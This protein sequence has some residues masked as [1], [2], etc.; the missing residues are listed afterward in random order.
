MRNNRCKSSSPLNGIPRVGQPV[1]TAKGRRPEAAAVR[2]HPPCKGKLPATPPAEEQQPQD[3]QQSCARCRAPAR[4]QRPELPPLH[5]P[6][7]APT[8][9]ARPFSEHGGV[10]QRSQ[11]SST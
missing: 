11:D 9:R 3:A 4:V 10:A 5:F 1:A 8:V 2:R 6:V 7:A